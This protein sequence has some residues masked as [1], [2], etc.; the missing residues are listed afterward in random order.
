[1]PQKRKV[2]DLN[3]IIHLEIYCDN[4]KNLSVLPLEDHPALPHKHYAFYQCITCKT[5]LDSVSGFQL[6]VDKI[7]EGLALHRKAR[8]PFTISLVIQQ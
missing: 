2:I 1:M 3:E 7:R 5:K 4:C 6:A 8:G